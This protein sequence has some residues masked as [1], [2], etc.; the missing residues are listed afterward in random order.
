[1]VGSADGGDG[2]KIIIKIAKWKTL[3]LDLLMMR[4]IGAKYGRES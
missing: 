2:R 4:F 1:M 3:G